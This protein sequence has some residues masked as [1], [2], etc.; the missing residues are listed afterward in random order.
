MSNWS[1]RKVNVQDGNVEKALR[2]LKKKIAE[3]NLLQ[4]LQDRQTYTKPSIKRRL[5]KKVAVR[6]WQK[7]VNSQS[8]PPKS[9]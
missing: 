3:S 7:Y 5:A 2:K 4:D 6:R 8:L 9:F 1:G